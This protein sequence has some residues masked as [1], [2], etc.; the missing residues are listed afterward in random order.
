MAFSSRKCM[1]RSFLLSFS[2]YLIIPL[3][4]LLG[5]RWGWYSFLVILFSTSSGESAHAQWVVTTEENSEEPLYSWEKKKNQ[6]KKKQKEK[7]TMHWRRPE[8]AIVTVIMDGDNRRTE[9]DHGEKAP[10]HRKGIGWSR[11]KGCVWERRFFCMYWLCMC[12]RVQLYVSV[13]CVRRRLIEIWSPVVISSNCQN[14]T[15][16]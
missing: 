9:G 5:K 13:W 12:T 1:D 16:Q 8:L 4:L 10:P 6:R 3:I 2:W 14:S 7:T 11:K 15:I